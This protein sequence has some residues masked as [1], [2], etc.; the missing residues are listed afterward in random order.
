LSTLSSSYAK[1]TGLILVMRILKY[2][3]LHFTALRNK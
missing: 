3:M 2:S 1:S